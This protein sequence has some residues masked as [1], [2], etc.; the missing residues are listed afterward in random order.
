M[1]ET[2]LYEQ[3]RNAYS[4]MNE[5]FSRPIAE[6]LIIH[7]VGTFGLDMLKKTKLIGPTD[8]PGQYILWCE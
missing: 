7:L 6:D 2:V 5:S 8:N 3:V 4:L 1:I